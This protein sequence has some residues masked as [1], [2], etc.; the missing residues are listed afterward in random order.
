MNAQLSIDKSNGRIYIHF[1]GE[2]IAEGALA[3]KYHLMSKCRNG[4][5]A[6][7]GVTGVEEVKQPKRPPMSTQQ[8]IAAT[9]GVQPVSKY[10]VEKRFEMVRDVAKGVGEKKL[11]AAVFTGEGGLGKSTTM[12]EGLAAA[13]LV[14]ACRMEEEAREAFLASKM[15]L[16]PIEAE[17]DVDVNGDEE[18]E[19]PFDGFKFDMPENGF[20]QIKGYS[21][22]RGLYET[23]YDYN[24]RTIVFDD[25]DE[26][27]E[28]K[29]AA[30]IFKGALD[31]N[32]DRRISWRAGRLKKGYPRTFKFTGTV[33]FV[34]NKSID[35]IDGPLITRANPIDL[36]L[37]VDEKIERMTTISEKASFMPHVDKEVI[38][39]CLAYVN[40]LREFVSELNMRTLVK[41]VDLH[42]SVP[43]WKDVFEYS[44]CR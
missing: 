40:E 6:S 20:I 24:G 10:S 17:N 4:G 3:S 27:L 31:S 9:G 35:E 26:V 5:F 34:T 21:T 15:E 22:A 44:A 43:N 36:T 13:G 29:T 7:L 8:I 11:K 32:D 37:S 12:L 28:D 23:L 19:D 2:Q 41:A 42:N 14:D 30:S 18:E 25:C 33:I 39:E 38:R 16:V 1:N